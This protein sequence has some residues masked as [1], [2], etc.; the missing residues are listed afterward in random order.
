MPL[1]PGPAKGYLKFK[2]ASDE[3]I[4]AATAARGR[5]IK[6]DNLIAAALTGAV[7]VGISF[8]FFSAGPARFLVGLALGC[9]YA[10]GF[11]YVLHRLVLHLDRGPFYQ[12]HML[13]HAT[14]RSAE[15]ARY[16]NFSSNPLGVVALIVLNALPFLA[17]ER[18]LHAGLSAGI[19][20]SFCLYY[21]LFEEIHWRSHMG[22][23]LPRF[24]RPAVRHHLLHH[25]HDDGRFNVFL[26][27]WDSLV[28]TLSNPE[29]NNRAQNEL[30]TRS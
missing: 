22:G 23:W 26:P 21:I 18:A 6:R 27:V 24:L 4:R 30:H 29:T 11:E 19:F 14:W 3:S 15:A 20:T 10:N 1:V 25:V 2:M 12:Q 9:L 28:G 5:R 8:R 16:V 13:H 7:L 17:I